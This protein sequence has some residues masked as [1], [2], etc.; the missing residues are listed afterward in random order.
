MHIRVKL[1]SQVAALAAVLLWGSATASLALAQS[2]TWLNTGTTSALWS[3]TTNWV[4]GTVPGVTSGTT[5]T[6]TAWL[7]ATVTGSYG[8]TANPILIDA[9]RTLNVLRTDTNAGSYTIGTT[10]GNALT[11]GAGGS[12]YAGPSNTSNPLIINAPLRLL[13]NMTVT[14]AASGRIELN[15]AIAGT[16]TAGSLSTL[17]LGGFSGATTNF[18]TSAITNG[19]NGGTVRLET[20][21][22]VGWTLSGTSTLGGGL[23]IASD[24]GYTVFNTGSISAGTLVA[25]VSGTFNNSGNVNTTTANPSVSGNSTLVNSGTFGQSSYSSFSLSGNG[26]I[27]NSGRINYGGFFAGQGSGTSYELST[28]TNNVGGNFTT[29]DTSFAG[30]KF[31]SFTNAG[32]TYTVGNALS[33]G[34]ANGSTATGTTSFTVTSGTV[35]AGGSG[36]ITLSISGSVSNATTQ[37]NLNGGV[38]QSGTA[39]TSTFGTGTNNAN[40]V[41]FGGGTLRGTRT[42]QT[43]L[44]TDMTAVNLNAGGGTIDL[45]SGTTN[46]IAASM[47]GVGGLTKTGSGTLILTGSNNTYAGNTTVSTGT[48]QIGNGSI[49]AGSL[50]GNIALQNNSG[51][52]FASTANQTYAG[53]ISG[54]GS[55]TKSSVG[56]VL[57]LSGVGSVIRNGITLNSGAIVN[58]GSVSTGSGGN[59]GN[60]VVDSGTYTNQGQ[61]S[62]VGSLSVASGAS[63]V[64][65]GT[66]TMGG[67]SFFQISGTGAGQNT[68]SMNVNFFRLN[69]GGDA[70]ASTFVN[71]VNGAMAIDS[72]ILGDVGYGSFTNDGGRLTVSNAGQFTIGRAGGTTTG[73]STVT[74]NSGTVTNNN[75]TTLRLG[76]YGNGS[77]AAAVINLNGGLFE[78]AG[79]LALT[80]SSGSNNS[81]TINFNGGTLRGLTNGATLLASNLTGVTFAAGGGT[82]DLGAGIT[83]TAAASLTGVGGL[84]K[85]GS[86]TLIFTSSNNTYA[87]NSTVAAGI[88]QVGDGSSLVGSLP[89]NVVLQNNGGLTFASTANQTY[90]GLISGTGSLTKSGVGGVLT[91][92]GNGSLIRNGITLSSGGIVNTGSVSTGSSGNAGNVAVDSGTYTNQGQHQLVGS[93]S[94]AAGAS[95]VN[96][97]TMTMGGGSFFQ[98]NG[99]GAGQNSGAMN[100]NFFR[101]NGGANATPS[102]FVNDANGAMTIDSVIL[103]DGGFGSFTNNGGRL[104]VTNNFGQFSI[105]R[106]TGSTTGTSALTISSGTVTVNADGSQATFRLGA[107]GSASNTAGVINLNGG[108]FETVAGIAQS[109]SSGTNNSAF[110]NF[111]G[112]TLRGLANGATL[113]NSNLTGV[114]LNAGG[115]TIDLGAGIT[116]TIAAAM[117]GAGGLTKTGAGRLVLSGSNTFGGLTAVSAGELAVNGAVAAGGVSVASGALLAGSGVIGGPVNVLDGGI[118]GPG[119]SP[120]TLTVNDAFSLAGTSVLAFE[121]NAANTTSGGGINDLITGVTNLTLAGF[122]DITG[123][124]DWTNVANGSSWRLF[125]YSGTLTDNGLAIRTAPTLAAG[126]SFQISTATAN[127]VNVVVVPE[128]GALVLAGLGVALA[129]W[130]TCRQRRS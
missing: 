6:G 125:N 67:G 116:N 38:F 51:V 44:S 94:V 93:L 102:T 101:L 126:Q 58:T 97:G 32:G 56:G 31:T 98:V 41:N 39:I 36:A 27:V 106:A 11:F 95:V 14:Q 68:G 111:A 50:P 65:S 117:S 18:V 107:W 26:A 60:V 71:G 69:G 87:G 80:T 30:Q 127:Q 77:N 19:T 9:G 62:F 55:L 42:N 34:R 88:L 1:I 85:S 115:G 52:T 121:L 100:V 91:L 78:T 123:S 118:V 66:M 73:T 20:T 82:I 33:I 16:G 130:M 23:R 21:G 8:T 104:T 10:A 57:T 64:N 7:A 112:G 25:I 84:T 49:L 108:L 29:G 3:E 120:G 37:L 12:I 22:A 81:A 90:A 48:L 114:A 2:G 47:T 103:G 4:G 40:V 61:H 28:F 13:G 124:G 119:N 99:T 72:F 129:G 92:S 35:T 43:L 17:T 86:G 74:V 75:G 54:T 109:T 79:S 96:S 128:P 63:V 110:V 105:G 53:L 122:L 24:A 5:V 46:T 89:G 45:G 70:A 15:G 59:A 113:L 83:S 76:S